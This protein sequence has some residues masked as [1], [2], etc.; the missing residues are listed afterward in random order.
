[1]TL[2]L[3]C[4]HIHCIWINNIYLR[5]RIAYTHAYA[6]MHIKL[7]II[8]FMLST[9][10]RKWSKIWHGEV[11][12]RTKSNKLSHVS[13]S[14]P[15]TVISQHTLTSQVGCGFQCFCAYLLLPDMRICSSAA[16]ACPNFSLHLDSNSTCI[17]G[18]STVADGNIFGADKS[19][20]WF[21][22]FIRVTNVCSKPF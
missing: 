19:M 20:K 5:L 18:H 17:T 22:V 2:V 8:A 1:M 15:N 4:H 3:R 6:C 7:S 10:I 16:W 21:V 11:V 12:G 14:S 13:Y 9:K